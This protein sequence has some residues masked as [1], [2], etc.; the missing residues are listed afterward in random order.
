MAE[1]SL[2][3]GDCR[4]VMP[5]QG[6]VDV[7]IAD[8][9]YGDTSLEWDSRVDGWLGLVRSTLKPH[10]SLWVS[11]SMR[12]FMASAEHFRA[13]GRRYAQDVIWEK[14]NGSSFHADRFKRVHEH[15]VQSGDLPRSHHPRCF[16]L[17]PTMTVPTRMLQP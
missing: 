14:H 16:L 17:N 12:F 9:P 11:G 1:C 5:K 3:L 15:A 13:A 4:D 8:P 7:V 10:G 2:I 6:L